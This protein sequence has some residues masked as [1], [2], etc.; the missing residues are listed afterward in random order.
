MEVRNERMVMNR[1]CTIEK[2]NEG[3]FKVR[4]IKGNEDFQRKLKLQ[5]RMSF[6]NNTRNMHQIKN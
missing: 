3:Y 4:A 5:E 6:N 1:K 2:K